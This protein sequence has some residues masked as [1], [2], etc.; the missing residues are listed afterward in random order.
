MNEI[1]A[2]LSVK[3]LAGMIDHTF[4]K[5]F[6]TAE[7]IEKLCDEARKYEFA[8]VAINPAEV[9]TCVKL[10]EGSPVRVGAAIGFPLGQTTTECKAFETRDA[11]A[12]G[13]TEIDTVINVRALQKG[14]LDIVKKEIEE[15]V[16][17][18]RPAGVI[19]KVILETCYLSDAEK[20]TVCRIAKEAGVDFVKT[21]TGFGTAGATV[22]D[23]AL[24]R[25]VVGPEIGVK[26]AG[27]IRDLDTAL[28]MIKAGATRIGT[29]SGVTIV[30]AYK[31]A[32]K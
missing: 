14:R 31:S 22:E 11:I 23:V 32:I 3:Q 6:G 10:L 12:K 5:P 30:E 19:C 1:I 20:E 18:C 8:M 13:A 7:N 17:I 2:N 25:R 28:A 27:G 4:L 9:E 15:M 21:S 24:M 16:A 26:A 29:S